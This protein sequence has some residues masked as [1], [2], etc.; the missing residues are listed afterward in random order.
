MS[1]VLQLRQ[2][3]DSLSEDIIRHQAVLKDLENKRSAARNELNS[4]LDPMS[5]SR[6]PL[7]ISS[8]ILLQSLSEVPTLGELSALAVVSRLWRAVA[9]STTFLWN[10]IC[11]EGILPARFP[12]P[13]SLWLQRGTG[14]PL[15]VSLRHHTTETLPSTFAVL[16]EHAHR[17]EKLELHGGRELGKFGLNAYPFPGLK[18][19]TI[20]AP[21]TRSMALRLE[22]NS[23]PI[24]AAHPTHVIRISHVLKCI[25]Y[26]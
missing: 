24:Y 7:E 2:R 1:S 21:N 4:I 19:L 10:A 3:I 14:F 23:S 5:T 12:Q 22:N 13:L 9:L 25:I 6:V 15:S 17:V 11:D 18:S 20:D 26:S 8:E 16:K